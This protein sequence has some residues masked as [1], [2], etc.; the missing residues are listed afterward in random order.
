MIREIEGL[1]PK[2]TAPKIIRYAD[3]FVVLHK[4][5]ETILECK[6]EIQ[7]WLNKVGLVLNEEKTRV[8]HTVNSIEINDKIEQPG[9][10]FLGFNIRQYKVGKHHSGKSGGSG[11]SSKLLGHKTIIKPSKKAIKKHTDKIKAVTKSHKTAPQAA[12]I[13]HLNP[14]I[15]GWCNYY[16]TVAAKEI[17]SDLDN[18]MWSRLRGWTAR[19]TVIFK[20]LPIKGFQF[21]RANLL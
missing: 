1:Y 2:R 18:I 4:E 17:F 15:R 10:D 8:G 16:S 13:R 11:N 6:S 21:A 7:T 3:D 12:L 20:I 14:I 5:L 9:F 19:E